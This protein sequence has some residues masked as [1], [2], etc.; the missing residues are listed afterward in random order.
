MSS[1]QANRLP[2]YLAKAEA[3]ESCT[4]LIIVFSVID[5]SLTVRF[6]VFRC[7]FSD[8]LAVVGRRSKADRKH[9][10]PTLLVYRRHITQKRHEHGDPNCV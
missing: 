10:Q 5:L 6:D 1:K 2:K 9:L 4:R 7:P 3:G 8:Y